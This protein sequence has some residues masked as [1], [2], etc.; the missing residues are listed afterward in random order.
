MMLLGWTYLKPLLV[1]LARVSRN[2]L[3]GHMTIP[4][5]GFPT[6]QAM[7][8]VLGHMMQGIHYAGLGEHDVATHGV[9]Y[10]A[11]LSGGK[12]LAARAALYLAS[13]GGPVTAPYTANQDISG[14]L[15]QAI[16]SVLSHE[17]DSG[18]ALPVFVV[19]DFAVPDLALPDVLGIAVKGHGQH[20]YVTS[21]LSQ[22]KAVVIL[23]SESTEQSG[24]AV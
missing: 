22:T 19:P 10:R 20:G 17:Q 11:G 9:F 7:M 6:R 3:L 5:R 12:Y 15:G 18:L 23:P 16:Q 13:V 14:V 2:L 8:L 1:M 21:N 4:V 24:E